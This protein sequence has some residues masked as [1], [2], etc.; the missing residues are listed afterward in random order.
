M[1]GA[2]ELRMLVKERGIRGEAT[3]TTTLTSPVG[4]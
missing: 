4:V 2:P 3:G 1:A